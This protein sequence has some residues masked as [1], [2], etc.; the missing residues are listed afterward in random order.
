MGATV[1]LAILSWKLALVDG[2]HPATAARRYG[3]L[4]RGLDARYGAVRERIADVLIHM[5]ETFSGLRVV[6]AF[7]REQHNMERFGT[8]NERNYERTCAR[9]GISALYFPVVEWLGG[10]A[11]RR[12]SSST[13]VAGSRATISRSGTVAAFVFYLDFIF[14][15]IQNLSQVFDMMQSAGRR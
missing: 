14:Q 9:R 8:I 15:P 3:R 7:A 12:S 4:P 10:L 2:H 13:A 5:Q 1:I 6:Q 11:D